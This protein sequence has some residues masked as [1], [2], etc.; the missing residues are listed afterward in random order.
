MLFAL[1]KALD[2]LFEEGIDAT[3]ERHRL[4]ARAVRAAVARWAS[5]APFDFNVLEESERADSV[6]PVRMNDGHDPEPLVAF[7]RD[8]CGVTLGIGIGQLSGRAFRI[9]H[10]GHVNAPMILGTLG[11]IELGLRR[12][13]IAHGRG[14]VEAAID[15]LA[16][17]LEA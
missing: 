16:T 17:G 14:G 5:E 8:T 11:S 10:M 1:D 12:L 9:A 13:G 6:T 7:C 3:F 15:A 2:L 4:L